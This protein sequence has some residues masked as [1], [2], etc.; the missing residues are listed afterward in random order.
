MTVIYQKLTAPSFEERCPKI[1][2]LSGLKAISPL[3]YVLMIGVIQMGRGIACC[4][5]VVYMVVLSTD[6]GAGWFDFWS[7]ALKLLSSNGLCHLSFYLLCATPLILLIL[8]C[9]GHVVAKVFAHAENQSRY[10]IFFNAKRLFGQHQLF[11]GMILSMYF[12][13]LLCVLIMGGVIVNPQ[14]PADKTFQTISD[15]VLTFLLALMIWHLT[16]RLEPLGNKLVL[17]FTAAFFNPLLGVL[18]FLVVLIFFM[19]L[20]LGRTESLFVVILLLVSGS[21]VSLGIFIIPF[22]G[23]SER[24]TFIRVGC[25]SGLMTVIFGRAFCLADHAELTPFSDHNRLILLSSGFVGL[26]ITGYL[27]QHFVGQNTRTAELKAMNLLFKQKEQIL[28]DAVQQGQY[29][30]SAAALACGANPERV[31]HKGDSLLHIATWKNLPCVADVLITFGAECDRNNRVKLCPLHIAASQL[32]PEMTA[33]L[34]NAGARVDVQDMHG[35]SPI[36]RICSNSRGSENY[37]GLQ[38]LKMLLAYGADPHKVDHS[39][40]SAFDL[41]KK[42]NASQ[43]IEIIKKSKYPLKGN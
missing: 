41:A 20:L 16:Y 40:F 10:R 30:I 19:V 28:F 39:G 9:C 43:C 7:A 37:R 14:L 32:H 36:H 31:D 24:F 29:L 35:R 27:Y 12:A 1:W 18:R 17:N 23:I 25:Q 3:T 6:A 21:V 33:L 22:S 26:I 13:A 2:A 5:S 15:T 38:C 8:F 11:N 34:L 4:T 42:W